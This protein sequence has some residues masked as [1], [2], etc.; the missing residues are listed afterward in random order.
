MEKENINHKKN[1][2]SS[3][4]A[5]H[6]M[7]TNIPIVSEEA[8]VKDVEAILQKNASDFDSI[9]YI[10]ILSKTRKLRG[11]ISIRELF[12]APREQLAKELSTKDVISVRAHTDQERIA[13][14]A[15]RHNLKALPVIDKDDNFL[16]VVDSDAIL[17]VLHSENIEDVLRF[18]G[19]GKLDNPAVDIIKSGPWLH[20]KKRLP[21]LI[22]GLIGGIGAAFV[23]GFFEQEL[24]AQ[25]ALAAFIPAIV[26]MA[27]AVGTQTQI[28]FIRS[29]AIDHH[30]DIL[31]YLWRELKVN[32]FLA[33]I[34]GLLI[35]LFA[36]LWM[37]S[38]VLC[39]I[40]G[41]SV[42]LTV[43]VAMAVA[44][45]MPLVLQKM[46]FDPA[47]ASGPFATVIRDVMS[48]LIYLA[49]AKLFL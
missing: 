48:L 40:L 6:L 19:S 22:F 43:L 18:A 25:I 3:E 14:L 30:L 12:R 47:I 10:Y 37:G 29:L 27:D 17:N 28:I 9:N 34:L 15:L 39:L 32:V 46:N 44:V 1:S 24:A 41:L 33:L 2:Y 31:K 26:Y 38:G 8:T 23:V 45:T 5:G 4:L 7:V 42:V 13:L 35:S 49:I 36:L 11:V 20:F 16:G 21:W